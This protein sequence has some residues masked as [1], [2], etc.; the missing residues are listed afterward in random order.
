MWGRDGWGSPGGASGPIQSAEKRRR[1]G[2]GRAIY[3]FQATA[4]TMV[5]ARFGGAFPTGGGSAPGAGRWLNGV[6]RQWSRHWTGESFAA[7]GKLVRGGTAGCA[8]TT[9]ANAVG[10]QGGLAVSVDS[11][12]YNRG[13]RG[14][15]VH[16]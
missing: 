13:L 11:G 16:G 4:K 7:E 5:W 1:R 2:L 9:I 3:F 14:V 6:L 12:E 15:P 8:P 10:E